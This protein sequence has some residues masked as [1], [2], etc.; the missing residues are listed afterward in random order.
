MSTVLPFR[1]ARNT[2][3]STVSVNWQTF[4]QQF[5]TLLTRFTQDNNSEERIRESRDLAMRSSGWGMLPVELFEDN[6][7]VVVRLEAAGME[8]DSFN[9]QVVN[10]YLVIRGE[11]QVECEGTEGH[12]L[13]TE[14]AYGRFKRTIPLPDEV[15]TATYNANYK[16]GVLRVEFQKSNPPVAKPARPMSMQEDQEEGLP[17]AAVSFVRNLKKINFC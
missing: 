13:L 5:L 4:N 16:N 8:K 7:K 17:F 1:K 12:Y 14:C 11:K 15:D 10:N 2:V 9:M 6:N 3:R